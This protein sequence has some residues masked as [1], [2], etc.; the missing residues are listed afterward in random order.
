MSKILHIVNKS[1]TDQYGFETCFRMLKPGDSVLMI[2]DG[3]Y[4]ALANTTFANRVSGQMKAATF[5]ALGPDIAARGLD[6]TP[7]IDDLKVVDYEGFVDLV[8]ATDIT[9]SWL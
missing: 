1:P 8:T 2:E 9:Q 5:Y 7:L 3:V 4:G 6:D